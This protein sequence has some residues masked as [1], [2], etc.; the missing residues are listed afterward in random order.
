MGSQYRRY[1]TNHT[2]RRPVLSST[3]RGEASERIRSVFRVGLTGGIGAGKSTVARL[4]VARGATLV[5]AD[6]LA[7]EA[8][9][10]GSRGLE[11]VVEAFGPEVLAADGSL[12]RAALGAVVF[13]DPE[14]RSRLNAVLH[15]R[16][17]ALTAARL[18]V[19]PADTVVV[20]D[21]PLLVENRMGA[22]YH[23]VLVVH[24]AQ[25][26][27]V[28]RLVDDRGMTPDEA[29]AR[30][31]AQAD[32]AARR[33]AADVWIDNSGS[34]ADV[35]RE[36]DR[37]WDGRIVPFAENL[38]ARRA[39]AR[40]AVVT[41]VGPDPSWPDQG[42]RLAGRVAHA[43][44]ERAVRVDHIG[45]TSVPGLVAKDVV[46][47]QLVVADLVAGNAVRP[48]L[49]EAGFVRAAGRWRDRL[50]GGEADKFVHTAAD[51]ARAMNLHVRPADGPAWGEA[52]LFRDWLRAHDAERDAYAAVKTAAQGVG[53]EAYQQG[54][55]PW[56][57]AALGRARRWAAVAGRPGD[58][59]PE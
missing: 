10:P 23:L 32:D 30:I 24:A 16:I 13:A 26:E 41:L 33:S 21:V 1:V 3:G 2:E 36:V 22:A 15:P 39:A 29:R 44:G 37:L 49:E 7:R 28:R 40:P 9:E 27:R 54:K 47:L 52:L 38:L 53:I 31:A 35:A 50:P 51:P 4:L 17:A 12:D 42:R 25:A 20:H 45:S 6:R 58:G 34:P 43:V 46:D 5:D 55:G 57:A 11:A 8:V 59:R 48:A 14:A 18:A 19:L 56:I